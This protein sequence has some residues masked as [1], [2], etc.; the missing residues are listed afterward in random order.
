[1]TAH[2]DCCQ[3]HACDFCPRCMSGTCCS[4]VSGTIPVTF[5]NFSDLDVLRAA[6]VADQ[7][8]HV[9]FAELVRLDD[10][11]MRLK[12][13]AEAATPNQSQSSP[14]R[15]PRTLS[16]AAVAPAHQPDPATSGTTNGKEQQHAT[17]ASSR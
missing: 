7:S 9:S 11:R 16:R 13:Q 17:H 12:L 5:A 8:S 10:L 4:T 6:M 1:M 14:R 2:P 3:N 15:S